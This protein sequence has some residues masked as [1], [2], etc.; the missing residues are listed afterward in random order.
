MILDNEITILV[1]GPVTLYTILTMYRYR[2]EHP[3]VFVIPKVSDTQEQTKLIGE[4][5]APANSTKYDISVLMYDPK[6]P[7]NCDNQQNRYL[8]F[9]SVS[10]GLETVK[11]PY[12]IKIRSDE[13][14]SVLRP[15][16]E[17][18]DKHKNKVVTNDVYFRKATDR[19]IHPSDHLMGGKTDLLKKSFTLAKSYCLDEK[20]FKSNALTQLILGKSAKKDFIT[21]EQ[22]IGISIITSLS[23]SNKVNIINE[24]EAIQESFEIVPSERLTFFRVKTN[25]GGNKEYFDSAYFN[26][27]TDIKDIR[28][29]KYE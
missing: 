9:F 26:G 23:E 7:E 25:S 8:H 4:L 11:T 6:V 12:A 10:L 18:M 21:A 24:T 16:V 13:F 1:H 27:E 29:Y 28:D 19:P 15:F 20:A 17:T 5:Y 2:A 22:V 14:Y 3:M